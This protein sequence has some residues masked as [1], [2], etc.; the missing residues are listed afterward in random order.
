[1]EFVNKIK[2]NYSLSKELL[3]NKYDGKYD[4][5]LC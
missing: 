2:E 4:K 1:M 5:K 3:N